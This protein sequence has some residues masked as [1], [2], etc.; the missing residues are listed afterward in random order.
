MECKIR[1]MIP[2]A[3]TGYRPPHHQ[4]HHAPCSAVAR[5][6]ADS[7]PGSPFFA[8]TKPDIDTQP[9]S[10]CRPD[11]PQPTTVEPSSLEWYLARQYHRTEWLTDTL[12]AGHIRF[13]SRVTREPSNAV[14]S[15]IDPSCHS[16]FPARTPR[17]DRKP[18]CRG[19]NRVCV[20]V[21]R[22]TH[23]MGIGMVDAVEAPN[24]FCFPLCSVLFLF[25]G[26]LFFAFAHSHRDWDH[27]KCPKRSVT[28]YL[29]SDTWGTYRGG[30][31][32]PDLIDQNTKHTG[33]TPE[34]A[35]RGEGERE[36]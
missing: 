22:P 34:W 35:N 17:N 7:R 5:N 19:F 10:A 36:R 1:P 11:S 15:I 33:R 24:L 18:R 32:L 23:R 16:V 27:P 14:A 2:C 25:G 31:K 6:S 3:G 21:I 13:G 29:R 4:F 8:H 9:H 12:R 30:P 28:I 20:Y 26:L